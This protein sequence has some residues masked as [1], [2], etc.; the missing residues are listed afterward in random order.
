[1]LNQHYTV[2]L[3]GSLSARLLVTN[4]AL[5]QKETLKGQ[6][7]QPLLVGQSP[8]TA[9]LIPTPD[10]ITG[11]TRTCWRQAALRPS[12]KAKVHLAP[13]TTHW[14]FPHKNSPRSPIL[15]W[16]SIMPRTNLEA[17][18]LAWTTTAWRNKSSTTHIK[19]LTGTHLRTLAQL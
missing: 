19:A 10:E 11:L 5:K 4:W 7:R 13:S 17:L 2:G 16:S 8:F 6:T 18:S 15:N 1:M 3:T 12:P 9:G 14:G